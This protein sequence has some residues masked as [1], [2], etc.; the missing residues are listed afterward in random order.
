MKK[1]TSVHNAVLSMKPEQ[2][3]A[4]LTEES[5]IPIS[6]LQL[7][8]KYALPEKSRHYLFD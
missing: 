4:L 2:L 8:A 1:G 5:A 6:T 3:I 7:A